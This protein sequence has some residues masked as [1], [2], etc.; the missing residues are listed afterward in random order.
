MNHTNTAA[1]DRN[2]RA[3]FTLIELLVVIAIIAI[4]AAILFPVFQKVRENARR[5]QAL[6]NCR[7]LTLA[8][9]QYTQDADEKMPMTGNASPGFHAP[10]TEWQE[11][12]YP[13]V[14][15]EKAYM[16]PDD[17]QKQDDTVTAASNIINTS[18][19]LAATSF[20]MNVNTTINNGD[21]TRTSTSLASY[22][23]PSSFILLMT[24]NRPAINATAS[25]YAGNTT[26]DHNGNLASIW[27][28]QYCQLG[29]GDGSAGGETNHLSGV[30]NTGNAT[31]FP[32]AAL[33]QGRHRH[34][35]S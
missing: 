27:G 32:G 25:R 30:N 4:L 17:S 23:S 3:G 19:A 5:T 13:F 34:R 2:G 14:K 11:S 35:V 21:G 31:E 12:I 24:G 20:L 22:T 8:I 26:P 29:G 15:S 1:P 6:S 28:E 7:Q 9:V 18:G 16:D 33:P 10:M